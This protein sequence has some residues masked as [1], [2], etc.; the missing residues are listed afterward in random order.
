ASYVSD[1]GG[2]LWEGLGTFVVGA[3]GKLT[4]T[5]SD[6]ANGNVVADGVRV[7]LGSPAAALVATSAAP[8]P[9]DHALTVPQARPALAQA[10]AYW[11]AH[12]EDTSRL[13]HLDLVI[14]DLG[15]DRLG[16]ASGTTITLDD[17]AAGWGW[18]VGRGREG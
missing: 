14:A 7:V 8:A 2:T 12:G 9:V 18:D 3:D 6:L 10:L 4:V 5:L 13:G 17:N 1:L 11:R 15:G 16:E